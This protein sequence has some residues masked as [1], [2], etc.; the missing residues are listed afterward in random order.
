MPVL[1]PRWCPA[2][3][4]HGALQG[5]S[6]S[7]ES[8]QPAREVPG[9][10]PFTQCLY[11]WRHAG[12]CSSKLDSRGSL[13]LPLVQPLQ[14]SGGRGEVGTCPPGRYR[15]SPDAVFGAGRT[16]G[17]PRMQGHGTRGGETSTEQHGSWA[18]ASCPPPPPS[19][20]LSMCSKAPL[21]PV[22]GC[23]PL[24][25]DAHSQLFPLPMRLGDL[26]CYGTLRPLRPRLL[27]GILPPP[28][29]LAPHAPPIISFNVVRHAVAG[30]E[31]CTP[32]P[33]YSVA[34]VSY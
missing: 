31:T 28:P 25:G 11:G 9:E 33:S 5:A 2:R 3:G 30:C 1:C 7:P 6:T 29:S 32:P 22:C 18:L 23:I 14:Y 16:G 19:V 34:W 17:S 24:V 21:P 15:L 13:G 20:L 26:H 27:V 12:R 4:R 10:Y 8:W